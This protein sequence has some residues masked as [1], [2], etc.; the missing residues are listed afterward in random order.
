MNEIQL[1]IPGGK[2]NM[3]FVEAGGGGQEEK[4]IVICW[5]V[6]HSG[7]SRL[8]ATGPATVGYVPLD[9]KTRATAEKTSK[10]HDKRILMPVQDFVQD[11]IKG[12]R[13]IKEATEKDEKD[14]AKMVEATK[15][16]YRAQVNKIMECAHTLYDCK[17]VNLIEIDLFGQFYEWMKYA[18]YGR[19]G[20]VVKKVTGGKMYK[21]TSDADQEIIDF[22]N[23]LSGKHLI[24]TH[25]SSD[26][27]V[28]N[29]QTGNTIWKGFKHLGHSCNLQVEMVLNK[30]YDANSDKPDRFWHYGLNIV[31]SLHK[32]ELEGEA[33]QLV[34][35]DDMITFDNLK[36]LVLDYD[37]T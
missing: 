27:Y 31:K 17:D 28:N 19:T 8:G 9:R 37:P 13:T 6:D 35:M 14:L 32:P 34:L 29:V 3:K 36:A 21:D 33:G 7:K 24:L 26:E 4:L 23:S 22:V 15:S 12:V 30:K 16:T 25:K 20:N 11:S 1:P 5:G 18:Y 2:S 10:Q